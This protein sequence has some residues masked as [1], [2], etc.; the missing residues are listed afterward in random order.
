MG[1][2]CED[3]QRTSMIILALALV[4][5]LA[6]ATEVEDLGVQT[7]KKQTNIGEAVKAKTRTR[8]GVGSAAALLTSGS[9]TMMAGG[10]LEEEEEDEE[11]NKELG[12]ANDWDITN[13]GQCQESE[14]AWVLTDARDHKMGKCV[15][16]AAD[17]KC[18]PQCFNKGESVDETNEGAV[19]T[20]ICRVPGAN[21]AQCNVI[22]MV[23]PQYDSSVDLGEGKTMYLT[24]SKVMQA[25]LKKGDLGEADPMACAG[26]AT[27]RR[28]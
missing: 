14:E 7:V 26:V 23:M 21:G 19:C 4:A 24:K 1:T 10:G 20:K 22:K 13:G 16:F 5:F 3:M 2:H 8:S 18:A 6:N 25:G 9:F 28:Q 17:S 12:E 15:K 27:N 11:E